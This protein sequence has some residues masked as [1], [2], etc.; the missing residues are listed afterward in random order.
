MVKNY[1]TR[2][3]EGLSSSVLFAKDVAVKIIKNTPAGQRELLIT[4]YLLSSGLLSPNTQIC[5]T[6]ENINDVL[7]KYIKSGDS[8]FFN[9]YSFDI[10][11]DKLNTNGTF[12]IVNKRL[13]GSVES[14]LNDI[15]A[16]GNSKNSTGIY[17]VLFTE[18]MKLL[19]K[20]HSKY[21]IFHGDLKFENIL[22]EYTDVL[23]LYLADFE[24]SWPMTDSTPDMTFIRKHLI[25]N[26]YV[27]M[28]EKNELER[29]IVPKMTINNDSPFKYGNI[30]HGLNVDMNKIKSPRIFAL[31]VFALIYVSLLY[32]KFDTTNKEFKILFCNYFSQFCIISGNE[33]NHKDKIEYE[34]VSVKGFMNMLL[35]I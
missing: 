12:F 23:H 20:L 4:N 7:L 32:N 25:I 8:T 16:N 2:P 14:L 5:L 13:Q 11:A 9:Q 21:K 1:I 22:Y 34:N 26:E 31:D 19:D 29:P 35:D 10:T 18:I 33:R 15:I 17:K 3:Q 30:Y 24:W 28:G 27:D 6:I